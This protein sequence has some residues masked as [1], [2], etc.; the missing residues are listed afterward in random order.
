MSA[1]TVNCDSKSLTFV[2]SSVHFKWGSFTWANIVVKT[3]STADKDHLAFRCS[4]WPHEQSL[5]YSGKVFQR[6]NTLNLLRMLVNSQVLWHLWKFLYGEFFRWNFQRRCEMI[7]D[8]ED[9]ISKEWRIRVSLIGIRS[10]RC[11]ST[12]HNSDVTPVYFFVVKL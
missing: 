6:T 1:V 12:I 3:Q 9:T 7:P 10:S 5:D 11:F 2:L 8:T 4:T